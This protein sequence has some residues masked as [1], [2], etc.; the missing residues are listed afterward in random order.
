MPLNARIIDV[1]CSNG[2]LLFALKN[3]GF[4]NLTGFDPSFACIERVRSKGINAFNMTLPLDDMMCH[5]CDENPFDMI[6]LSHVLEHVFDV[7]SVLIS[8]L[9]LLADRGRIYIETPDPAR[10]DANQF[11]PLYFFDSEHINHIGR[12]SLLF[13]ANSL[14][15]FVLTLGQKLIRLQNKVCYPAIYSIFQLGDISNNGEALAES[16]YDSLEYYVDTSLRGMKPL[17]I[18]I[19]ALVGDKTPFV[20]WGAG[21]LAQRLIG[22]PWFPLHLLQAIVDRD[23]KKHGLRFAG[24][25]IVSPDIGLQHLPEETLILCAAAIAVEQIEQDYRALGLPYKFYSIT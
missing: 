11:P 2:G 14:D 4:T 22:E 5:F 3:L 15:L 19:M 21:S 16:L 20:L 7:R 23:S 8:L 1:G 9:P 24:K 6:I 18:K 25:T 13:L 10:Y 12:G 17:H